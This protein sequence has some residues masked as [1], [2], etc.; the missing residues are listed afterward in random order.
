MWLG[1]CL[2]R[3]LSVAVA[4]MVVQLLLIGL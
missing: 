1:L 4:R 3:Q 2:E